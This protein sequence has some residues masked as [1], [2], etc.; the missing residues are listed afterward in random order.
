VEEFAKLFGL[1]MRA[2]TCTT[3]VVECSYQEAK[4]KLW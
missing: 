1:E 4:N 3:T 2:V